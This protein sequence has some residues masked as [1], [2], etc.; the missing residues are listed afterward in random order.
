[1]NIYYRDTAQ[2]VLTERLLKRDPSD[3]EAARIWLDAG[4]LLLN[5]NASRASRLHLLWAYLGSD[6]MDIDMAQMLMRCEDAT[7]RAWGVRGF[8]HRSNEYPTYSKLIGT[9]A[10]D[11][12]P[13]VKLQVAI[14]ARKVNG[15]DSIPILLDVLAHSGN[16]KLIPHIVWQ[17]L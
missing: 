17:N 3:E 10:K 16:D 7:F 15:I 6:T 2:R 5:K 4:N 13:D 14:A 9:M 1:P 8:T 12:S 11:P